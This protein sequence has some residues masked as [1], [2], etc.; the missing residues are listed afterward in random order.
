MGRLSRP[1]RRSGK[2]SPLDAH[3]ER[4]FRHY[5]LLCTLDISAK[6]VR[7]SK[8][9]LDAF[10]RIG[11]VV[12]PQGLDNYWQRVE[13]VSSRCYGRVLEIGAGM[14]NVTRYIA[15]NAQVLEVVAVD[16]VE[17][18][19]NAL[20]AR[21]IPKARPVC[22]NIVELEDTG[23]FDCVVMSEF[24]EHIPLGIELQTRKRLTKYLRDGSTY[25]ISTPLGYM[26]DP[27]HKRGFGKRLFLLHC[28]LLYG[29]VLEWSC[30]NGVNQF[31]RVRQK[32]V[33]VL[34]T[35][36]L[37]VLSLFVPNRFT[38]LVRKR[39]ERVIPVIRD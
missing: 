17:T 4:L 35:A 21:N 39:V 6:E 13:W 3:W 37:A 10:G 22:S 15:Q 24:V 29:E 28:R 27:D 12:S 18:Y 7:H 33:K 26:E 19:V 2:A 8:E 5:E 34:N 31:A 16:R 36:A 20:R 11:S 30:N 23:Q 32:P 1:E 14:G 25:L 9:T 38:H